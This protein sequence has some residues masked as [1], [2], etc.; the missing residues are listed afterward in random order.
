MEGPKTVLL[1]P[2]K[3]GDSE[4]IT[5]YFNDFFHSLSDEEC[6]KLL[7][8][9]KIEHASE[10][11][12]SSAK[13]HNFYPTYRATPVDI[14]AHLATIFRVGAVAESKSSR[15]GQLS[16]LAA[17]EQSYLRGERGTVDGKELTKLRY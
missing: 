3:L 5:N 13:L 9:L 17:L 4:A 10:G 8:T 7:L 2:I 11:I 6:Q 15:L 1:R 16:R 12:V 14:R